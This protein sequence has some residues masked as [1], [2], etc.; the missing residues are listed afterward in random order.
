VSTPVTTPTRFHTDTVGI[1][2]LL[3][4]RQ[5]RVPLHQRSYTWVSEQVDDYWS[6][7]L[8]ALKTGQAE[9]FLGSTVMTSPTDSPRHT[10]IDGQQRLATTTILI[11]AIRNTL[12]RRGDSETARLVEAAY[13][14]STDLATLAATARLTLNVEDTTFFRQL[15]IDRPTEE[16]PEVAHPSH[17]RLRDAFDLLTGRST[18]TSL[19]T[20]RTGARR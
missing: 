4:A 8:K 9:Y 20:R 14:A 7:L 1:A 11:S 18:S 12:L 3:R 13:L 17:E 10:I 6:D 15:V 19:S 5:L 2:D 16:R